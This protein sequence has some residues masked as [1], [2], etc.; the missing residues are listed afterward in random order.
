MVLCMSQL[1]L[2]LASL[3]LA[4]GAWL[5]WYSTAGHGAGHFHSPRTPS[6]AYCHHRSSHI[7]YVGFRCF[8]STSYCDAWPQPDASSVEKI[9]DLICNLH[10]LL[11]TES[12]ELLL[13]GKWFAFCWFSVSTVQ[14]NSIWTFVRHSI[15]SV[16]WRVFLLSVLLLG[17]YGISTLLGWSLGPR[18]V[19]YL[20]RWASI[21]C[22]LFLGID[23]WVLIPYLFCFSCL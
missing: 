5:L 3:L 18:L 1:S 22:F 4:P 15:L 2:G 16:R 9:T 19:R 12:A 8:V 7:W 21:L 13:A 17:I 11:M 6:S 20:L 14:L 10:H 23:S